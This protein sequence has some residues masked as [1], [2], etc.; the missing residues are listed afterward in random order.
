ME[1]ILVSV[2]E[3]YVTL[4]LCYKPVSGSLLTNDAHK[5]FLRAADIG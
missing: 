1:C 2:Y 3:K 4:L 5:S